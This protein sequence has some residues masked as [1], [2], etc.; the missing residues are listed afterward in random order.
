METTHFVGGHMFLS[1][2]YLRTRIMLCASCF[3]RIY[4][5]VYVHTYIHIHTHVTVYVWWLTL[6]IHENNKQKMQTSLCVDYLRTVTLPLLK[7]F[8]ITGTENTH[9]HVYQ[10]T[11]PYDEFCIYKRT[12]ICVYLYVCVYLYMLLHTQLS[13]FKSMYVCVCVCARACRERVRVCVC[14]CARAR[15]FACVVFKT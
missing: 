14:V 12:S 6:C 8:G 7:H 5:R 3:V 13:L 1:V 9:L 11:S 10:H 15:T 4:M 2:D